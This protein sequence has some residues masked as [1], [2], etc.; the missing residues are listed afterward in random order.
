MLASVFNKTRPINYIILTL[1]V[2]FFYS[3][4]VDKSF[5]LS[6]D[7]YQLISKVGILILLLLMIYLA[8]FI[9]SRNRLAND[10]GY[11]PLIFVSFLLLFPTSFENSRVV[12][13]SFFIL[14]ALRRIF[15]L[16]SLKESKEKIF[17]ASLWICIASLFHF[18]SILYL[19]LLFYAIASFGSKDYRNWIIP[20]ISFFGA[21]VFLSLY[22]LI[23]KES[24][25]NWIIQ[26]VQVSFDFM[27]FENVYQNIA[28]AVFVSI[29]LLY[30]LSQLTSLSS[31][32]YNMQNV[33]KKVIL[34]FVI[35]V[36]I[37][38]VSQE[39]NNGMLLFTFFP[40]A[41]LGANYIFSIPQNW[42]KE[43]NTYSIFGIGFFF[44]LM[45]LIL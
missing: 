28:L 18:W 44:Y 43:A 35:G 33:Y 10:T 6:G 14:L 8:Q 38:V 26:K 34:A 41:I 42:R 36:L 12:I 32:P 24:Y 29:A 11:V 7:T 17:D 4:F 31:K 27:Y 1:L 25:Y 37:Y 40:L 15:S 30:F 21:F 22:L 39:K 16:H 5:F 23:N 2:V 45:Q 20:V 9:V 3:I 13:A 19:I